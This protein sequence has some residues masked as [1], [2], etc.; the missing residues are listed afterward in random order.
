LESLF[1]E[2]EQQFGGIDIVF[3][4][5]GLMCGDPQW[6][7]TPLSRIQTVVSV[8][9]LAVMYGTRLAIDAMARRGGGVVINTASVAA[10]STMPADPMYS[11]TKAAVVNFTQ[12]C[13][14]LADT[15]N[16]RINAVLPGVTETSIL[17]KSGDG[18]TPADWLVPM[19]EVVAKLQPEDIAA[20][21]LELIADDSRSGE[22]LVVNNPSAQG[23][24]HAVD[25]L[26]DRPAFLDYALTRASLP[27]RS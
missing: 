1:G 13:A 5:A 6:P 21:A 3:N 4:N 19:L 14:P 18:K 2:V 15:H 17:V 22:S 12:S 25:R 8:N 11:S 20:A 9:L 26:V 7:S 27:R 24:A 10:F 16:V 23:E